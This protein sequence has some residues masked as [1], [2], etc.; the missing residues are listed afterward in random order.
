MLI[1]A[2]KFVNSHIQEA[3]IAWG[4]HKLEWCPSVTFL[5]YKQFKFINQVNH[6]CRVSPLPFNIYFNLFSCKKWVITEF[7]NPCKLP[8]K[9]P[10]F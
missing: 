2:L 5:R 1:P 6:L 7:S 3:K 10:N 9:F 4:Y 8:A